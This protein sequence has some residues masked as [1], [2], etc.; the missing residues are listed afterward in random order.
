[1]DMMDVFKKIK[2]DHLK[3]YMYS[4]ADHIKNSKDTDEHKINE[5]TLLT[6]IAEE[7]ICQQH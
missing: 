1:M 2:S 6:L 4:L 7:I 3:F 5:M